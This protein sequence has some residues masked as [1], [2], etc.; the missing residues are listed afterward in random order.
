MSKYPAFGDCAWNSWRNGLLFT[1]GKGSA[2]TFFLMDKGQRPS[3]ITVNHYESF[4][5]EICTFFDN[6]IVCHHS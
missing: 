1:S 4:S 5:L 3:E 2:Q 6:S